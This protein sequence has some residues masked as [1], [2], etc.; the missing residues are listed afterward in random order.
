M[1]VGEGS[2]D[3]KK[4]VVGIL[5]AMAT[6]TVLSGCTLLFSCAIEP[7]AYAISTDNSPLLTG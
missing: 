5:S 6:L 7:G 2:D 4:V 3:S 1:V